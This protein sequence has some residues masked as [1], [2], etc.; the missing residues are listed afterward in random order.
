MRLWLYRLW[1]LFKWSM[2]LLGIVI[3]YAT[4]TSKGT[5][6]VFLIAGKNCEFSFSV[7]KGVW[8]SD[9][10]AS[11]YANIPVLVPKSEANNPRIFLSMNRS[12]VIPDVPGGLFQ[13]AEMKCQVETRNP[14]L[15]A[16]GNEAK[17]FLSSKCDLS[18]HMRDGRIETPFREN[19][20]YGYVAYKDTQS[21]FI[22][23]SSSDKSL[24]LK[25]EDMVVAALKSHSTNSTNCVKQ[26]MAV[27]QLT[28]TP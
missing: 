10:N 23:L 8:I 2:V 24:L 11:T 17:F 6:E 15:T 13:N 3:T 5:E 20:L 22:F 18:S 21:D 4:L 14:I 25:Q 26:R 1:S 27:K 19:I 7:P 9:S 28:I 12:W 16:E